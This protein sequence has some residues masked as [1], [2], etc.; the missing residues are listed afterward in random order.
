MSALTSQ[1]AALVADVRQ[2]IDNA[3]QRVAVTV[4]AQLSLL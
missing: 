1:D 3:R 4:N 2:L